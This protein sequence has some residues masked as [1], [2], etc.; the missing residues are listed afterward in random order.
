MREQNGTWRMGHPGYAHKHNS[1]LPV[2]YIS[3]LISPLSLLVA[4]FFLGGEKGGGGEMEGLTPKYLLFLV[5]KNEGASMAGYC[6]W[7]ALFLVYTSRTPPCAFHSRI[8]SLDS[9]E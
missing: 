1:A 2:K 7:L 4:D 3:H 8:L 9:T 6:R 5:L